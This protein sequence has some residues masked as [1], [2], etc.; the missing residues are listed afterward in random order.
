MKLSQV[1]KLLSIFAVNRRVLA[2]REVPPIS[3]VLAQSLATRAISVPVG[4]RHGV[5]HAY[6]YMYIT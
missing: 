6:Q 5:R 1:E 3:M 2:V 4:T